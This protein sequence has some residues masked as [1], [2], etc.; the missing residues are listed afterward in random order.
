MENIV[1]DLEELYQEVKDRA[2][3]EGAYSQEQW[4]DLVDEMLDQKQQFGETHDDVDWGEIREAIK[5][6]F[7]EFAEEIPEM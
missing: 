1:L 7:V 6:R 5:A 2:F 3:D 4:D